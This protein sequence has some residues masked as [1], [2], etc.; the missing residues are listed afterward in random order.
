MSITVEVDYDQ[1]PS[2]LYRAH[3]NIRLDE[4]QAHIVLDS[5]ITK[6]DTPIDYQVAQEVDEDVRMSRRMRKMRI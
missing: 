2:G 6:I 1:D 4:S 5:T 3:R